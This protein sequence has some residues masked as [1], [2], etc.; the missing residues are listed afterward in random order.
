MAA[1]LKQSHP[2]LH[3]IN[4]KEIILLDSQSTIDVFSNKKL[5]GKIKQSKKPLRLQSNSGSMIL[6]KVAAIDNYYG[7]VWYLES[8]HQH[9]KSEECYKAV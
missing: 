8:H 6:K 9:S 2:S 7:E 1:V 5:L 3:E 4:M